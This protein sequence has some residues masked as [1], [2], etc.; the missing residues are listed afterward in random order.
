[1]FDQY[2]VH[3]WWGADNP[4]KVKAAL[5]AAEAVEIGDEDQWRVQYLG[6]L[7]QQ[8]QEWEYLG[9]I[10]EK[11]QIQRLINSPSFK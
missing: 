9:E 1:M 11:N 6:T 2:N 5:H 7:L 8:R 10:Q 3:L 4:A